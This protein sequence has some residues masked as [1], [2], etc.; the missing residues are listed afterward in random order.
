MKSTYSVFTPCFSLLGPPRKEDEITFL[1]M[2]I[3]FL[4]VRPWCP[5]PK[6]SLS[7]DNI[8]LLNHSLDLDL[9]NICV[10]WIPS[11]WFPTFT[12]P[13]NPTCICSLPPSL[14]STANSRSAPIHS[15]LDLVSSSYLGPPSIR[16]VLGPSTNLIQHSVLT[17]HWDTLGI[18]LLENKAVQHRAC[19]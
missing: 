13:N 8:S 10:A 17:K 6:G 5:L 18:S 12:L 11:A 14:A 2:S 9:F 1:L 19:S 4:S 15:Q 7:P 16:F 3:W